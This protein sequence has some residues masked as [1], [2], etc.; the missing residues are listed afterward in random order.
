MATGE[1]E[2]A[3]AAVSE[4]LAILRAAGGVLEQESTIRMAY[5]EAL[6]AVGVEAAGR[7]AAAAAVERCWSACR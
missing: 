1:A 3:L 5:V 2:V 6:F 4:E 7:E